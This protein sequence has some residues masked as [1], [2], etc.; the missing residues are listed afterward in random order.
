MHL[1]KVEQK[2][3]NFKMSWHENDILQNLL[4]VYYFFRATIA[5]TILGT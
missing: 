1:H 5:I 3:R 2:I 4:D